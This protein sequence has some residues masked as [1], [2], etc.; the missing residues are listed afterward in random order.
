MNAVLAAGGTAPLSTV[1]PRKPDARDLP[2][3]HAAINP[4]A[5]PSR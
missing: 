4:G 5:R 3:A 2:A 1:P